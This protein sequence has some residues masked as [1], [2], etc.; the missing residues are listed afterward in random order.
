MPR[1]A[2]VS[3][4]STVWLMRRNP[5]PRMVARWLSRVLMG[6]RTNVTLMV[7]PLPLLFICAAMSPPRDLFHALP[8]L[9]RYLGRGCHG[10]ERVQ[11]GTYDVI[12]VGRPEAF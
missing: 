8:T 2:G 5:S 11:R 6:L 3:S 1:T 10:G 12:G 7:L 4:T 9:R